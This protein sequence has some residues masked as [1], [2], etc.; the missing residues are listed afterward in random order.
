MLPNLKVLS[1]APMLAETIWRIH[2]GTSVGAL[3][4]A[5]KQAVLDNN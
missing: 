1:V 5:E 4:E 2:S 3:F